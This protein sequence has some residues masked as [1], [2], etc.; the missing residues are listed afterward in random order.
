[1]CGLSDAEVYM[2]E[3][4]DLVRVVDAQPCCGS[5]KTVDIIF[6]VMAIYRTDTRCHYCGAFSADECLVEGKSN[7]LPVRMHRLR[8]I[9]PLS[10][11]EDHRETIEA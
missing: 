9:P 7:G 2:I 5:R 4:G 8:K 1:M 10:E 6:Q 11:L 3:V